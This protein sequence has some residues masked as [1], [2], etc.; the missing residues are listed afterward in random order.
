MAAMMPHLDEPFD[1]HASLAASLEDF[2]AQE[3][4]SPLFD[5]PSQVSKTQRSQ[6]LESRRRKSVGFVGF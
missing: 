1:D 5:L 3:Q 6:V 2:E 4:R